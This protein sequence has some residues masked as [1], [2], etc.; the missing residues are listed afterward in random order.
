MKISCEYLININSPKILDIGIGGG[1]FLSLISNSGIKPN[2]FGIELDEKRLKFAKE[3]YK[4]KNIYSIPLQDKFWV[5]NHKNSFDLISLWDV[6]EHVNSP[7]QIFEL[8]RILLKEGGLL[9]MDTPCRDTFY[10][11]FGELTY[12]LSNG[13]YATFLNIMYSN[14]PFGHKQILSKKDVGL[15]CDLSKHKLKSI[16]VFHELS[17]PIDSYLRK[18]FKRNIIVSLLT[19]LVKV[20]LK[21]LRINNKM[22]FVAEKIT[23]PNKG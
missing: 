11:R 13:K 2:Y 20:A 15:L 3:E 12:R 9:I 23:T 22:L 5:D 14:Q 16:K 6:L 17:F 8:S 7:K 10:H 19:P 4:L 18:M 1:L 21:L